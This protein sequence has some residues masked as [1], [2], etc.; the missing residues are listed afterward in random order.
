MELKYLKTPQIEFLT[1]GNYLLG[2]TPQER[3][4]E[5]I[6]LVRYYEKVV[7]YPK[8]TSKIIEYMLDNNY[9]SLSS[10]TI[11]NFGRSYKEDANTMPLP[12]SC[13]IVTPQ[14]SIYDIYSSNLEVAMLSKLG[15][16][17]GVDFSHISD[18]GTLLANNFYTNSKIDWMEAII[19]T[20]QKV[21][22]NGVRRGYA[23]PFIWI[24][25]ADYYSLLKAVD[26]KN[27]DKTVLVD[28]TVGIKI[29]YGFMTKLSERDKDAQ[30]RW[31]ALLDVRKNSGQVYILFAEN[32]N[33][34]CSDVYKALELPIDQ[35]NI[36]TEFIQ[37]YI[38]N[39]TPVCVL[40][41]LNLIHWDKIT[42]EMIKACIY[43]LDMVNEE[44]VKLTDGI[45][46]IEKSYNAAKTR[47]DIGLGTLGFH[48]LLQS[49]MMAFGGLE[50]R[51]LNNE[52]YKTIQ[53][54]SI[55][56]T[57]DLAAIFGPCEVAKQAG[58]HRRNCSLNMIA[59]NKSTSFLCPVPYTETPVSPGIE[60][61]FSN[62]FSKRL[63][64]IQYTFKN[65]F[66]E[67]LL[68]EKREN[69]FE[70]WES[71]S[72]NLGS[73][74]HLDFLS[75][76]EKQVFMT[77]AEISPKDII[78]LAADRQRYIDMGQSLNLVNR[79]NYKLKDLHQIHKYAFD[80]GIKTLYYF[81]PQAHAVLEKDGEAWDNCISCAD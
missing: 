21:S 44:Y 56:A 4:T 2:Q 81:Y 7:K 35:T 27:T 76:E 26:K 39:T 17:V 74:S 59:P 9:L 49:K 63:A 13:N 10:P 15:A 19:D 12:A 50:S 37:P 78:D 38:E 43:F 22:Q 18:R 48:S 69:K 67:R 6:N 70:V 66:L 61:Y 23:V 41:A 79:P 71:I 31:K 60:A 30:N 16:G 11:A 45:K 33:K 73:V 68:E 65:P 72:N 29:P 32:C 53:E 3:F 64:K 47:R 62:I 42:P 54:Y 34:N 51:R 40:A 55:K 36:C 57:I 28:N 52:I 14:D 20:S 58:L 24:D 77:F 25:D 80:K 5:I 1:E 75:L 8:N 46:G